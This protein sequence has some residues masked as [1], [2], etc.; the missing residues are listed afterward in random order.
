MIYGAGRRGFLDLGI[1][2]SRGEKP[3][4]FCD[5][6]S[7]KW[8]TNC[9]GL[10]VMG[11]REAAEKHPRFHLHVALYP[12]LKHEICEWLLRERLVEP[13]R[14]TNREPAREQIGCRYLAQNLVVDD[15]ILVYCCANGIN[16][17]PQ[18]VRWETDMDAALAGFFNL[19]RQLLEE[20]QLPGKNTPCRGCPSLR[21]A[22]W[23]DD[24]KLRDVSYGVSAPCQFAC[25]YCER[26]EYPGKVKMSEP[27]RS[28]VDGFDFV[29]FLNLLEKREVLSPDCCVTLA[30]GEITINKRRD[31]IFAAMDKYYVTVF[32]NGALYHDRAASLVSRDGS[33]LY[34]S[35]DAGTRETF[36]KVKG[37][38]LFDQ[39]VA[40]IGRYRRAG[41]HVWLKYIFIPENSEDR[42]VDGFLRICLD[43]G[44]SPIDISSDVRAN[45]TGPPSKVVRAAV[46]L[47]AKAQACG[48]TANVLPAAWGDE[49]AKR[50]REGALIGETC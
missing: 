12:P 37:V 49:Y 27:R 29:K 34:I 23:A 2:R 32:S 50:I 3:V 5:A 8:G 20:N 22:Y 19:K 13:G 41:G 35:L 16:N 4:C 46:R 30:A 48:I 11:I 33:F 45:R 25:S 17:I 36:H 15:G 18:T 43:N 7:T 9:S 44:I 28:M 31:S 6:D 1:L 38:D 26:M 40:N 47:L 39:V 14:I 42:D 24:C 21:K 10:P